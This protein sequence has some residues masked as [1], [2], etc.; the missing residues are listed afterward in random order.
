M[1][2][3]TLSL[4]AALVL[5]GCGSA[6]QPREAGPRSPK[7]VVLYEGSMPTCPYREVGHVSGGG[8]GIREAAFRLRADAVIMEP[9]GPRELTVSGTAI[10]FTQ[11]DC[12]R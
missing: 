2:S 9:R 5:A 3:L 12:R 7:Y 4:A 11:A 6:Y 8:S 10:Q 1:R